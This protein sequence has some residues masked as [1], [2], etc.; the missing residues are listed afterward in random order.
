MVGCKICTITT[1]W[2]FT[3]AR[4]LWMLVLNYTD[5]WDIL[6]QRVSWLHQTCF[7]GPLPQTSTNQH[8]ADQKSADS[9]TR[10]DRPCVNMHKLIEEWKDT[11]AKALH[12]NLE[13][14]QSDLCSLWYVNL[15][16]VIAADSMFTEACLRLV[17][18]FM[19]H[20]RVCE[21]SPS[22]AK[23]KPVYYFQ[24]SVSGLKN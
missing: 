21:I 20:N 1:F 5:Q 11:V 14:H 4:V 10:D 15:K 13:F 9:L 12:L 18:I 22:T 16:W 23:I 2:V 24:F 19:L 8:K 17:Q 7:A 6:G 3:H